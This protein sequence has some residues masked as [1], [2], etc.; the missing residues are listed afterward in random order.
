MK[1]A[2]TQHLLSLSAPPFRWF[3][4]VN[5]AKTHQ[6][7]YLLSPN[8]PISGKADD[9]KYNYIHFLLLFSPF[10][11]LSLSVG[12][13]SIQYHHQAWWSKYVER[14]DGKYSWWL[15]RQPYEAWVEEHKWIISFLNKKRT[16]YMEQQQQKITSSMA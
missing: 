3:Y 14:G 2:F 10:S 5:S 9:S 15:I 7:G 11:L 6:I 4:D 16:R 8:I 1:F 13:S 12:C